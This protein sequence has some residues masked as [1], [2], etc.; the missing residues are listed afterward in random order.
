MSCWI[1]RLKVR[2]IRVILCM[3]LAAISGT[4]QAKNACH[5]P[6]TIQAVQLRQLQIEMM[7]ATMRCDS[8][9]YDFRQH[10]G[11]FME[12][13]NPLLPNNAQHLR[14]SLNLKSTQAFD[15]YITTLA[16]VSQNISQ[17][18]PEFCTQAVQILDQTASQ[19]SASIPILAAQMIPQPYGVTPCPVKTKR[20]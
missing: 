6:E 3:G 17:T 1:A 20:K 7:V 14:S 13:I 9:E 11:A 10:Y 2:L 15:R 5:S 4:A 16:N 12:V 19:P 18:N 8:S